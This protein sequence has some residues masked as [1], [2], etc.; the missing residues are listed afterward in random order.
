MLAVFQSSVGG[1]IGIFGATPQLTLALTCAAG[2]FYGSPTGAVVGL[3]AGLFTDSVG[4]AG[5][6]LLALLYALFGY[7]LGLYAS[8]RRQTH[9]GLGVFSVALA[10]ASG[11]GMLIT[12]ICLLVNA[13]KA[14]IVIAV[15][16]IA[17]PEALNTYIFGW[18]IGLINWIVVRV[19][20]RNKKQQ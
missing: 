6:P 7:F 8:D 12:L 13:G 1:R 3:L 19:C 15:L 20:E 16:N 17:L 11:I 4:S 5:I 18:A 9:A 2:C 10:A 14:N